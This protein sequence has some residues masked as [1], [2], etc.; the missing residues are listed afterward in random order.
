MVADDVEDRVDDQER[1]E[2]DENRGRATVMKEFLDES[3]NVRTDRHCGGH[4]SQ[5]HSDLASRASKR[6]SQRTQDSDDCT[7]APALLGAAQVVS[8]WFVAHCHDVTGRPHQ[9]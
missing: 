5:C 2:H 7:S 8:Y 1:E 6:R 9:T 4:D 3:R